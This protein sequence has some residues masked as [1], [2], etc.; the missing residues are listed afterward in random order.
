MILKSISPLRREA[1]LS[2]VIFISFDCS[3][4]D[5]INRYMCIHERICHLMLIGVTRNQNCRI[6]FLVTCIYI[7]ILYMYLKFCRRNG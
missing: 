4:C 6:Q 7:Y 1:V 2:Y 3:Y 5:G